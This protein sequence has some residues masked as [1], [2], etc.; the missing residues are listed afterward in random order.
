LPTVRPLLPSGNVLVATSGFFAAPSHFYEFTTG[1][2]FTAVPNHP[3]AAGDPSYVYRF[4]LLPTGQVLATDGSSSVVIFTPANTAPGSSPWRPAVSAFPSVIAPGAHYSISGTQFNGLSQAV[5]YGDD[6]QAATNYPLVQITNNGTGHVFYNKTDDHSTMAVA[7][8]SAIVST[9]FDANPNLE[10]GLST[11]VVIANGIPSAPVPVDVQVATTLTLTASSA[12]TSDY[13]DAATVSA[14][15]AVASSGAGIP[16]ET[17]TFVLGA[18]TGTETCTGI[19]DAT[20]VASC[21]ITPN[22]AAGAYTLNAT[23]AGDKSYAG[24]PA[25]TGFTIT[26][27]QDTVSFAAT[28]PTAIA[29][30]HSTTFSATLKEDGVTPIAGRTLTITLGNSVTAQTCVTRATDV[31]GTGSCSLLVNPP[32]GPGTVAVTFAGDAFY[33]PSSASGSAI[34]FAF[35]SSGSMVIGNQDAAMGTNVEFWGSDWATANTLSGGPAPDSF[36]GFAA[37]TPQ[38]CGG[39]WA[40]RMGNSSAPRRLFRPIW[41]SSHQVRSVNRATRSPGM[42]QPS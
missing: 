29:N 35:L 6:V 28:S 3:H 11:L 39:T 30:G 26:K 22:Q 20:G 15:L 27:E 14:N 37:T 10:P 13:H 42:I 2:A 4:L 33:L 38:S 31:T 5:A 9:S 19:T 21:S 12:T 40:S 8:G 34:L 16:G 24:S 25:S 32:L 23:F 17:I 18:G 1:N 36:K 41:A 7:T